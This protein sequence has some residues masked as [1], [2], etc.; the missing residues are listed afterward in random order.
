M[1]VRGE[2]EECSQLRATIETVAAGLKNRK[3]V[4]LV[5]RDTDGGQTT[6]RF[7]VKSFPSFL[8]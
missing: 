3:N 7:G 2:C 5:D 4:A 6:R 1:F 8:L